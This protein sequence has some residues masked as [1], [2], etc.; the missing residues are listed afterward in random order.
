MNNKRYVYIPDEDYEKAEEEHGLNKRQIYMRIHNCKWSIERALNTPLKKQGRPYKY[1]EKYYELAKK[2]GI[3][4][5]LFMDRVLRGWSFERAATEKY[6]ADYNSWAKWKEIAT[7]HSINVHTF[8]KRV[9]GLKWDA[10]VAATKRPRK[11]RGA[12]EWTE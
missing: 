1:D 3:P 10:E 11:K 8:R 12:N 5:R 6:E 4:L 9:Y 2:N 7:A